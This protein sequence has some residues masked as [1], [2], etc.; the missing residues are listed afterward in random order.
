MGRTRGHQQAELMAVYGQ[1][2]VALDIP[3]SLRVNSHLPRQ[4][5]HLLRQHRD[6]LR[7]HRDLDA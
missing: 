5:R 1:I 4:H 6:L 2:S 3:P 7:L